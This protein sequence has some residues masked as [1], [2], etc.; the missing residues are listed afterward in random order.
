MF[1]RLIKFLLLIPIGAVLLIGMIAAYFYFAYPTNSFRYATIVSITTPEGLVMGDA[2][3]EITV[4]HSPSIL[5]EAPP[6]H[7]DYKGQAVFI[8]LGQQGNLFALMSDGRRGPD[9]AYSVVYDAFKAGSSVSEIDRLGSKAMKGKQVFLTPDMYPTFVHF[10]DLNDPST[11]EIVYSLEPD[12]R[13]YK[14]IDN[15]QKIFGQGVY[16]HD[17]K[18]RITD[19]PVS[20][21]LGRILEWLPQYID[22][23]FDG[24]DHAFFQNKN[25]ADRYNSLSFSTLEGME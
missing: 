3:R 8:D 11:I 7:A 14:E 15:F 16:I 19:E 24:R 17:I 10:K 4:R 21:K 5:P 20:W 9:Y 25:A 1:K 23:Q 22:K 6:D 2:V 18:L 13:G 12:Q